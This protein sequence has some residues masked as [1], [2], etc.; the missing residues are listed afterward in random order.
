MDEKKEAP[1]TEEE[2]RQLATN[3]NYLAELLLELSNRVNQ[4]R[5][6]ASKF[7]FT[8]T[9]IALKNALNAL[10]M[11]RNSIYQDFEEKKNQKDSPK[12]ID[13]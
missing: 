12:P 8:N 13:E 1:Q 2:I 9:D 4:V 5:N 10:L 3:T 11:C 6:Q 7:E